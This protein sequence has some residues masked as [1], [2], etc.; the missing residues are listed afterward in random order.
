MTFV[1]QIREIDAASLNQF[2]YTIP[3]ENWLYIIPDEIP[4]YNDILYVIPTENWT[5]SITA[6]TRLFPFEQETRIYNIR[7]S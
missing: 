6:E 3:A 5:Y 4:V 7:S 1:A 2:V